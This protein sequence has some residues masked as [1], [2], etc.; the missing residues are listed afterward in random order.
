M[1]IIA[2]LKGDLKEY[3]KVDIGLVN[4]FGVLKPAGK[5]LLTIVSTTII[6]PHP[7]G[8]EEYKKPEIIEEALVTIDYDIANGIDISSLKVWSTDAKAEAYGHI[9][10]RNNR[11]VTMA[12]ANAVVKQW[13]E[14]YK[15]DHAML[16]D[17][18]TVGSRLMEAGT[19]LDGFIA[20]HKLEPKQIS[21]SAV[22]R[23]KPSYELIL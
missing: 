17:V 1:E 6:F 11:Y 21:F 13:N 15:G 5:D 19:S 22:L 14:I 23:T 2:V 4:N 9:K 12:K 10:S 18:D 8:T 20:E 16:V 7:E 3:K